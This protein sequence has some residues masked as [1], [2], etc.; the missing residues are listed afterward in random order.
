MLFLVTFE[1]VEPGP[2]HPPDK[3]T[4]MVEN[5]IVPT[6]DMVA[7]LEKAGKIKAAGVVAGSKGSVM[8][9]DVADNNELSQTVQSF[10]FWSFMKVHV[11]PLQK[12]SERGAQ[13]KKAVKYL[14][15]LEKKGALNMW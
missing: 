11:T 13:E 14:R 6:L 10:P 4:H 1:Y 5:A 3:V 8:I 12:F 7:Q 15:D 9:L 2:A